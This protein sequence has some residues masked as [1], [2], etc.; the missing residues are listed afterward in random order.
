MIVRECQHFE[1]ITTRISPNRRWL[2]AATTVLLGVV[3]PAGGLL[4]VDVYLL[5]CNR[6]SVC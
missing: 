1:E 2:F 6:S 4:L 5:S 3:V